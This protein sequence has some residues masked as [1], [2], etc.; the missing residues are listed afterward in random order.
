M[1]VFLNLALDLNSLPRLVLLLTAI[2][3]LLLK[4]FTQ[5][6]VGCR[7]VWLEVQLK[8]PITQE[9]FPCLA[10]LLLH[11]LALG[12]PTVDSHRGAD[13]SCKDSYRGTNEG[14]AIRGQG[15]P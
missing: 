13:D 9:L 6:L 1:L 4:V 10:E 2:S 12:V 3:Q 14:Q 15:L 11:F 8:D 7:L 5:R